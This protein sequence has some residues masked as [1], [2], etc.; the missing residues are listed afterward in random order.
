MVK[1]GSIQA[2]PRRCPSPTRLGA[3]GDQLERGRSNSASAMVSVSSEMGRCSARRCPGSTRRRSSR[4]PP[5]RSLRPW[6]CCALGRS[7]CHSSRCPPSSSTVSPGGPCGWFLYFDA[8]AHCV[9]PGAGSPRPR[10]RPL[11]SGA[12][13]VVE[14][15]AICVCKLRRPAVLLT[16]SRRLLSPSPARCSPRPRSGGRCGPRTR[17]TGPARGCL[18]RGLPGHRASPSAWTLS[19]GV[20]ALSPA[21]PSHPPARPACSLPCLC[22]DR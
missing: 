20:G 3:R 21:A 7:R 17:L 6:A 1:T 16:S 2:G 12:H 14:D 9:A 15:V 13:P 22:S 19:L 5:W 18:P 10:L 4:L 11:R 8:G